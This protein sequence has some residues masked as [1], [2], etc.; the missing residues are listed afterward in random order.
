MAT[1]E[2]LKQRILDL[3]KEEQEINAEIEYV[4]MHE[5]SGDST[6]SEELMHV[7]HRIKLS[8]EHRICEWKRKMDKLVDDLTAYEMSGNLG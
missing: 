5:I 7:L 4:Q 8:I 2:T 6:R 3:E 1:N